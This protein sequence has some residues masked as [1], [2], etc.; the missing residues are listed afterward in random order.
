[1]NKQLIVKDLEGRF[2][3]V[4]NID[5]FMTHLKDFHTD[6]NGVGN[7]TIHEENGY[8]FRVSP[9]FYEDLKEKVAHL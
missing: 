1:M 3:E 7:N 2:Y 8:Y 4:P 6:A 9:A 5:H